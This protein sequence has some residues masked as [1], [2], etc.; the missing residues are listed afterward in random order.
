MIIGALILSLSLI[1]QKKIKI[2]I[3]ILFSKKTTAT[4]NTPVV[5]HITLT[6]I[7]KIVIVMLKISTIILIT[8]TVIPK[9]IKTILKITTKILNKTT[10]ILPKI[11]KL[12]YMITKVILNITIKIPKSTKAKLRMTIKLKIHKPILIIRFNSLKMKT[13]T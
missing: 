3:T 13:C 12:I 8:P 1:I 4:L 5:M 9:I 7:H 6:V 11:T 2:N 10:K